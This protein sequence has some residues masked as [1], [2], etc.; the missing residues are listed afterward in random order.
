M[1]SD[2]LEGARSI[3]QYFQSNGYFD[4]DVSYSMEDRNGRRTIDYQI[5][6]G[7]RYRLVSLELSGNRYFNRRTLLERLQTTPATWLR[8]R[9]GRYSERML[10]QDRVAIEE[11]YRT[12]GFLDVAVTSRVQEAH[13]TIGHLWCEMVDALIA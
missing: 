7:D 8:Y 6:R 1:L 13:I 3:E 12:N 4:V 10:A 2:L 11:L 5:A 9:Q